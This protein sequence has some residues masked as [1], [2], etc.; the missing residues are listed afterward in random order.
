MKNI[1]LM[2]D[3]SSLSPLGN[4]IQV[5][6]PP[7]FP[8]KFPTVTSSRLE[9]MNEVSRQCE[10]TLRERV[11]ITACT[12]IARVHL[13]II[14]GQMQGRSWTS[15]RLARMPGNEILNTSPYFIFQLSVL[16]SFFPLSVSLPRKQYGGELTK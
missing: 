5:M 8:A 2:N 12:C 16:L 6:Q 11:V 9:D 7:L 15:R 1:N 4:I 3:R 13:P 10:F 14:C